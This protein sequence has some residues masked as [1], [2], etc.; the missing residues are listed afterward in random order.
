MKYE[1]IKNSYDVLEAEV[2]EA[3]QTEIQNSKTIS[4]HMDTKVIKVNVF[5]Y[6]ELAVI[7]NR[8]MFMDD[9]GYQYDIYTECSLEDLIDI[10]TEL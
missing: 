9:D 10:L 6:K 4:K 1:E 7:N 2:I 8:L 3:L 5:D